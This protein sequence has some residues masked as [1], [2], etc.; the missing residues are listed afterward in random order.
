MTSAE[1]IR[2]LLSTSKTLYVN[3]IEN[4]AFEICYDELVAVAKYEMLVEYIYRF[5]LDKYIK[6]EFIPCDVF[7]SLANK[8]YVLKFYLKDEYAKQEEI[9][10]LE[11]LFKL[12]GLL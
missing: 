8:H 11:T 6:H 12:K 4:Y 5:G 9:A 3:T 10:K 7:M 1:L 2:N